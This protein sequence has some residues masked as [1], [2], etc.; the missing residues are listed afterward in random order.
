MAGFEGR[1]FVVEP[2]HLEGRFMQEGH[3]GGAGF[4]VGMDPRPGPF[5]LQRQFQHH[6]PIGGGKAFQIRLPSL[7]SLS[8]SGSRA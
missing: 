3:G 6:G 4:R 8:P 5:L 2:Q 7:R 1:D